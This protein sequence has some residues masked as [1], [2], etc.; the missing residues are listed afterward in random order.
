M[1]LE[2]CRRAVSDMSRVVI[3]GGGI[4][5]AACAYYLAKRGVPATVVERAAVAGAASGKAGGFL[6]S[7]WSDDTPLG[8]LSRLGFRLH[9]QVG[10]EES[11]A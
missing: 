10:W 11:A 6:A 1:P 2:T 8:P 3:C 4:M 7:D 9:A 5:G